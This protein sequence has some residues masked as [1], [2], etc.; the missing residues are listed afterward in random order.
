MVRIFKFY[1]MFLI[2]SVSTAYAQTETEYFLSGN[3]HYE[4]G[5]YEDAVRN[6]RSL[7]DAGYE[8]PELWYNLGN[9][10]YK[11]GRI[12]YS[13]LSYERAKKLEPADESILYNLSAANLLV[14]DKIT[15]PPENFL[16]KG[17]RDIRDSVKTDSLISTL[18]TLYIAS[19]VIYSL[20]LFMPKG[21]LIRMSYYTLFLF[22]LI[23][24]SV[25]IM[26]AI[27]IEH[28]LNNVRAVVMVREMSVSSAPEEIGEELF[29][30][31]EGT[32]VEIIGGS[33][34]WAQIR[35]LDGKAGWVPTEMIEVI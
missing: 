2:L 3:R 12:G 18:I 22:G 16:I 15:P 17:L 20:T 26:T 13:V 10:Y 31:H 19:T 27:K 11:L 24:I 8:S 29:I 1:F 9:A 30:L 7:L 34:E 21:R 6:Y 28:E 35:L 4:I 33:Q 32:R 23:F 5:E 14:K 25:S